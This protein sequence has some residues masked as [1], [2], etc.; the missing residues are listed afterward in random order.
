ME[1]NLESFEKI[2]KDLEGK[3]S[4]IWI[5]AYVEKEGI[6]YTIGVKFLDGR[7]WEI[8]EIDEE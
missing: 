6:D 1:F 5:N 4:E 3:T 8:K 7:E 2:R